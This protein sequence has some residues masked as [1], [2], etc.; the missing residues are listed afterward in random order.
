M[1]YHFF[2]CWIFQGCCISLSS[3]GTPRN[4][5]HPGPAFKFWL[6]KSCGNHQIQSMAANTSDLKNGLCWLVSLV[7]PAKVPSTYKEMWVVWVILAGSGGEGRRCH[8]EGTLFPWDFVTVGTLEGSQAHL[9]MHCLWAS[10]SQEN[11]PRSWKADWFSVLYYAGMPRKTSNNRTG[12]GRL[13]RVTLG[14]GLLSPN[15]NLF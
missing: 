1:F 13:W 9:E 3:T 6:S 8:L 15:S 7:S 5:K 12:S 2:W 14:P 4:E 11:T 10:W